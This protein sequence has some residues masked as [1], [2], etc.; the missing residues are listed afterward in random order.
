M[1]IPMTL[2]K[3]TIGTAI[4]GEALLEHLAAEVGPQLVAEDELG[5]R[6]L[7]EQVVRGPLLA[8]GP[9][10]QV[11]V[12]HLGRVEVVT[13]LFFGVPGKGS[14]RVDD[15]RPSAVVEG[16]VER[17]ARVVAGQLLGP[18]HLLDQRRRDR[19]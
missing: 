11:G 17:H 13:E 10:D 8:G 15:L 4:L 3:P 18:L 2:A 7:P 14:S 12:V 1:H 5:I 9:D 19:R 16:D 6:C